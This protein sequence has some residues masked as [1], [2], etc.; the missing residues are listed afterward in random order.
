ML[1]LSLLEKTAGC[2]MPDVLHASLHREVPNRF[3]GLSSMTRRIIT[4]VGVHGSQGSRS[5]GS[6]NMVSFAVIFAILAAWAWLVMAG[7]EGHGFPA[8]AQRAYFGQFLKATREVLHLVPSIFMS[9]SS[10]TRM[11]SITVLVRVGNWES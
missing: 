6:R 1:L 5:H 10:E 7:V 8:M 9:A 3:K 11:H 2:S 4:Q